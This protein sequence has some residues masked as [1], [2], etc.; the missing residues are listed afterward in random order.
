[1]EATWASMLECFKC[2][3]VELKLQLGVEWNSKFRIA[4]VQGIR[5]N[6]TLQGSFFANLAWCM[7]THGQHTRMGSFKLKTM[8]R[9]ERSTL[10]QA[11]LYRNQCKTKPK[12]YYTVV[13]MY[14]SQHS[15][16]HMFQSTSEPA[17]S[18]HLSTKIILILMMQHHGLMC[19]PWMATDLSALCS[20]VTRS[21]LDMLL[22]R[23]MDT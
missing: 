22:L 17:V 21:R 5:K 1:M 3:Y 8:A 15:D 14:D 9:F 23:E 19:Q 18:P 6:L 11:R 20:W 2:F 16:Q 4:R 12:Y 7:T 13:I 10:K